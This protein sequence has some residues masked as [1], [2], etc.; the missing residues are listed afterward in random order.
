MDMDMPLMDGYEAVHVLRERGYD[1][2]IV[3][4]TAHGGQGPESDRARLL[5]CNAVLGKPITIERLR[6]ALEPFLAHGG[7][8]R[9]AP[10]AIDERIADLMPRFVEVCLDECAALQRAC[11]DEAWTAASRIGHTLRGTGGG[12]GF[13]E[14]TRIGEAIEAA[15]KAHDAAALSALTKRLEEYLKR[16]REAVDARRGVATSRGVATPPAVSTPP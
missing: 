14:V 16:I 6:A 12:Y 5:G 8:R 2:P 9:E 15:A 11:A 3:A 13:D 10:L 7:A 4:F 1:R